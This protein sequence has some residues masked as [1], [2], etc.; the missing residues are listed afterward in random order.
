MTSAVASEAALDNS[1]SSRTATPDDG[2]GRQ[3]DARLREMILMGAALHRLHQAESSAGGQSGSRDIR[4]SLDL[5]TSCQAKSPESQTLKEQIGQELMKSLVQKG[6]DGALKVV[7]ACGVFLLGATSLS[8][9]GFNDRVE[10]ELRIGAP[11]S[12]APVLPDDRPGDQLPG[13]VALAE[14]EIG[15][16]AALREMVE[17]QRRT[18]EILASASGSVEDV[19][20]MALA[21]L[22]R[23]DARWPG[24]R[25]ADA[26]IE[27]DR[28]DP[29]IGRREASPEAAEDTFPA[30]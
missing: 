22:E 5:V 25:G 27:T 28:P 14:S 8:L 30:P 29:M 24:R 6:V 17:S 2:A 7:G 18:L 23:L 3:E 11:A 13:N 12:Q 1:T 15:S 21:E 10:M 9:A 16:E 26:D 20:A 4:I 19:R